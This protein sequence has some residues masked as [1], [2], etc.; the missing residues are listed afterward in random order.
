MKKLVYNYDFNTAPAINVPKVGHTVSGP[1][2]I[3]S[4]STK[5]ITDARQLLARDLFELKRVYPDIL[6]SAFRELINMNFEMYPEI[7]R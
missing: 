3:V 1:N 2:G 6:N 4:R 7:R 5:G